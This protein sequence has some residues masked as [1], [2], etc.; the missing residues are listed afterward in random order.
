MKALLE[1]LLFPPGV[2]VL[3][4]AL[5]LLL[6]RT[7]PRI[8][9]WLIGGAF[10]LL[11]IISLPVIATAAMSGL[12]THPALTP[13]AIKRSG[14]Q[15][16]V[17]LAGGRY[18]RAPEYG[19]DTISSFTLERLRYGVHL[20]RETHLPLVL[21]GGSV[22]DNPLAESVLMKEV[23]TGD[24]AVP[25]WLTE[26][27]SRTTFENARYT[28][29]ELRKHGITRI[30]LVTHAWHM[31]RAMWSFEKAGLHVVAAPTGFATIDLK[32]ASSWLPSANALACVRYAL[33]ESLGLLWYR[34][35]E[36]AENS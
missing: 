30:L 8:G 34:I 10:G 3:I 13:E 22:Y 23:A 7:R 26:E 27:R 16:I 33:H 32:K 21:S 17:V 35:S 9:K 19:G 15:A 28:A 18:E 20:Q 24:F 5:G 6:L 14:A 1:S 31:P 36:N 29:A 4:A 12:Q 11:Y 25:V 2:I